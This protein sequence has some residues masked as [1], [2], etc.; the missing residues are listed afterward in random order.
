METKRTTTTTSTH[1][2]SSSTTTA[3]DTD[4][5][6]QQ[7]W[8]ILLQDYEQKVNSPTPYIAQQLLYWY[9]K[10]DINAV[11]YAITE[12]AGAPRPSWAYCNAVLTRVNRDYCAG[13]N[14]RSFDDS[15]HITPRLLKI[16]T[17][18]MEREMRENGEL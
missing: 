8:K 7:E 10:L 9:N 14:Y 17:E 11:S 5:I 3:G 1:S 16:R 15:Y 13:K 4:R 12:T 6:R 18:E 2:L